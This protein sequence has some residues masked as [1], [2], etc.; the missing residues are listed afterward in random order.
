MKLQACVLMMNVSSEALK[1][2]LRVGTLLDAVSFGAVTEGRDYNALEFVGE[3]FETLCGELCAD[4]GA[5]DTVVKLVSALYTCLSCSEGV[6]SQKMM[7]MRH[8][9][10]SNATLAKACVSSRL[11]KYL[12]IDVRSLPDSDSYVA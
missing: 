9:Y 12:C 4:S 6:S 10:V 1:G 2:N 8:K 7:E 3:S 11:Y 5:G